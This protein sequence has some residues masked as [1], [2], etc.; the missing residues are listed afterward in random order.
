MGFYEKL[1]YKPDFG[2]YQNKEGALFKLVYNVLIAFGGGKVLDVT[3][4]VIV[5]TD[6]IAAAPER[7]LKAGIV[8]T[9]AKWYEPDFSGSFSGEIAK[10]G[11]K[12][13][14]DE[15][16]QHG[17]AVLENKKNGIVDEQSCL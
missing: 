15:L 3:K 14:F 17:F 8:D 7:Y 9:L 1:G 2:K 6:I 4:A 5:D 13:A 16:V 12:L 11:S 10:K